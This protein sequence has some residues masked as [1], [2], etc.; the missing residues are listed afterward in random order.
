METASGWSKAR[1]GE[2]DSESGSRQVPPNGPATGV[3]E[4][5]KTTGEKWLELESDKISIKSA[6]I[7]NLDKN[8]KLRITDARAVS[9]T[10]PRRW[11][12]KQGHP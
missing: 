2:Q 1:V 7:T 6:V 10:R 9:N 8:F 4:P 11:A 5:P 12:D 3:R